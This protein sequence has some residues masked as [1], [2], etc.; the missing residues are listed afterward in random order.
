MKSNRAA[1]RK[2]WQHFK[3]ENTEISKLKA[4]IGE[5]GETIERAHI[6]E[7]LSYIKNTRKTIFHSF[8][9]GLARGFGI[10]IGFSLL[11]ALA[12]YIL[13]EIAMSNL[14]GIGKFIA[15]IVKMVQANFR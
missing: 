5:L 6:S 15:E 12:I 3:E 7:Y 2:D 13:Q 9:G 10:A 14:P 8:L 4:K 1:S 11:G